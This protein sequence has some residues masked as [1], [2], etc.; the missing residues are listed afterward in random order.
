MN[1]LFKIITQ[2]FPFGRQL[3]ILQNEVTRLSN[4]NGMLAERLQHRDNKIKQLYMDIHDLNRM[5]DE[6]EQRN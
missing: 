1:K 5:L 3:R 6:Y 2:L 4:Q